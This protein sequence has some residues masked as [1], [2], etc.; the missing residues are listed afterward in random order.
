MIKDFTKEKFDI[1]I[2]AGQSNAEGNGMGPVEKPYQPSDEVWFMRGPID[3]HEYYLCPA[4]EDVRE[5]ETVGNFILKFSENYIADGRLKEGRKLLILCAAVGGTGFL[6]KHWGMTDCYYTRMMD[7]I[8]TSLQL[9]AENRLVGLIWHQGEY[10]ACYEASLDVHYNHLGALLESVLDEFKVSDLPFV[11][12]DFV[13][14]WK[15]KNAEKCEPVVSAMRK[16]CKE[17]PF[18]AFV[19]SDGLNSNFQ[20]LNRMTPVAGN[21]LVDDI[22]FS[23]K[24]L[25][26]LGERYYKAFASIV[27]K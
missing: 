9:N 18:G 26:E 11:A 15:S 7:M 24:A 5:N 4:C 12:G 14:D 10:D 16:L 21:Y 22:H 13:Q 6:G 8:R 23:R 3:S 17:Y 25:Y 27:S 19:E 1:I 20:E 2:L